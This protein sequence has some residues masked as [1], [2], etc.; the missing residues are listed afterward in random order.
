MAMH[1]ETETNIRFLRSIVDNVP[2]M[3]FVKDADAL[4]F[5]R[6]NKAEEQI[7]GLTREQLIGRTDYDFFPKAE[8]DF[9]TSNDRQVLASGQLL[10]IPEEAIQTAKGMLILHT[11]KIPLLD[12][13]GRPRFLLGISEDITERKRAEQELRNTNRLLEESIHSERQAMTALKEVPTHVWCSR[14][15]WRAWASLWPASPTR[16]T[17]HSPS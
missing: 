12:E 16:S 14:K 11:K 9:F 6:V 17:I 3:V 10:D 7:L 13:D 15:R 8:A 5:V 1:A 2:V 4:R